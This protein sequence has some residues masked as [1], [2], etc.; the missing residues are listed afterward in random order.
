MSN[1]ASKKLLKASTEATVK[2]VQHVLAIVKPD[3]SFDMSGSDNIIKAIMDKADLYQSLHG[4]VTAKR[5]EGGEVLPV[6]VLTFPFLPCSPYSKAWKGSAMIRRVLDSVVTAAGYGKYGHKLGQGEAP[7]GWPGDAEWVGYAGAGRSGLKNKQ[8]TSIIVSMLEAEGI[9][10]AL[11]V[12]QDVAQADA[13]VDNVETGG[14]ELINFIETEEEIA[15]DDAADGATADVDTADGDTTDN[16]TADDEDDTA[17]N[18]TADDCNNNESNLNYTMNVNLP[19]EAGIDENIEVLVNL[20]KDLS[21]FEEAD[22]LEENAG[23]NY[24]KKK[25]NI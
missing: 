9:N 17:D 2:G 15:D 11:H 7:N 5:Q 19:N 22:N 13:S 12:M 23:E 20:A 6:I 18:D 1:N 4:T 24:S 3:G 16:N 25:R 14:E 10:P 8:M 21:E